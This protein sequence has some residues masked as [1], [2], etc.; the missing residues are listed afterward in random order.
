MNTNLLFKD[1]KISNKTAGFGYQKIDVWPGD[2]GDFSLWEKVI[3][4][5]FNK[6]KETGLTVEWDVWEEPNWEDWWGRD[7]DQFF[8]TYA[9]STESSEN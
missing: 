5:S 8:Q 4:D 3:E 6:V 2:N 7:R 1:K 9:A